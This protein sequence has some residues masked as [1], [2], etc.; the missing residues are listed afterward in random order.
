[1]A[2]VL[3]SINI[4]LV[5]LTLTVLLLFSCETPVQLFDT[6]IPKK[7]LILSP[8]CVGLLTEY[9]KVNVISCR[10]YD[11]SVM[12]YLS[13]S[14]EYEFTEEEFMVVIPKKEFDKFIEHGITYGWIN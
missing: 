13:D 6:D 8:F 2:V 12:E 11:L 1:M 9:P 7:H 4:N 14:Y 10:D 5:T 3:K